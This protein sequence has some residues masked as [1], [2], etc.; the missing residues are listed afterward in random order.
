M[1]VSVSSQV[2]VFLVMAAAG[3]G[4]GFLFDLLRVWRRLLRPG[5]ISTGISDLIFW[6]IVSASI[7]AILFTINNGELRW[8]ELL[9]LILGSMIYFLAFSRTCM[10][11]VSAVAKFLSKIL[12]W[13]FK[14]VLTPIVFLY[15]MV[16]RP[17]VWIGRRLGRLFQSGG[18]TC[19][20]MC[21][22][23]GKGAKKFLLVKKKS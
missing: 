7:F 1:E 15:R 22:W 12:L 23:M 14:I 3:I 8:F 11:V 4:C 19:K 2:Y 9:G 18:R 5:K 10:K 6:L 21:D 16:K 13:I 20:K 17:F